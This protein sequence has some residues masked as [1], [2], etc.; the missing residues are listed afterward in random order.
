MCVVG[1]FVFGLLDCRVSEASYIVQNLILELTDV[2][3]KIKCNF[4]LFFNLINISSERYHRKFIIELIYDRSFVK[5]IEYRT[6]NLSLSS[7]H[8]LIQLRTH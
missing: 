8:S 2:P 6:K 5:Y 4:Y 1:V 3:E 7:P